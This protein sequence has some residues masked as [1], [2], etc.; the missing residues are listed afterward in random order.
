M[1]TPRGGP[2]PP[3]HL[4]RIL[5]FFSGKGR[6]PPPLKERRWQAA[7]RAC[8]VEA[9][10]GEGARVAPSLGGGGGEASKVC[11]LALRLWGDFGSII[12]CSLAALRSGTRPGYAGQDSR[13]GRKGRGG[14]RRCPC[15]PAT[16]APPPGGQAR[17]ISGSPAGPVTRR[18]RFWRI[19][20]PGAVLLLGGICRAEPPAA[21]RC[22]WQRR[23]GRTTVGE[24]TMPT[25]QQAERS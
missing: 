25:P 23:F 17:R 5:F 3:P 1:R 19:R 18:A 9:G 15:R 10:A 21:C 6:T 24:Q 14:G 12:C 20:R 13:S 11:T 2:P 7:A 16:S 4:T 8:P 22:S